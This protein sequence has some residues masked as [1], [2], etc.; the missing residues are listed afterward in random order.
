MENLQNDFDSL[1]GIYAPTPYRT[2]KFC[3]ELTMYAQKEITY[4]PNYLINIDSSKQDSFL[5]NRCTLTLNT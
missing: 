2:R 5:D 1:E 4:A 3:L